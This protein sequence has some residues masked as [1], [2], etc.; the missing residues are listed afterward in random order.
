MQD[1][2]T[3]GN[4][5]ICWRKI[6]SARAMRMNIIETQT[7]ACWVLCIE[8]RLGDRQTLL[9]GYNV[10][11]FI[12][13]GRK[14]SRWYNLRNSDSRLHYACA[15]LIHDPRTATTVEKK[16]ILCVRQCV[17][18]T[19]RHVGMW[20]NSIINAEPLTLTHLN[21]LE[22]TTT[23][24]TTTLPECSFEYGKSARICRSTRMLCLTKRPTRRH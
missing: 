11:A 15:H 22:H 19:Y 7:N 2:R 9:A 6:W 21:A 8:S 12:S 1:E 24:T 5:R 10:F 20:L 17:V 3:D 16:T 14:T 23:T 13:N 18:S 4:I